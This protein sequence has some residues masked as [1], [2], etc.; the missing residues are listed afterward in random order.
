MRQEADIVTG[1]APTGLL[2]QLARDSSGNTL[3]MIAAAVLPL[4]AMVGGGIDMGRSYLS[5]TRLQQA[6]DAGVLAARKKLGSA[7]VT[8]GQ[9][10][11]DVATVGNQFFNVNFQDGS[12]GTENRDFAMTLEQ[13]YAISGVATVNVP[14][15]IMTIFGYTDVPITVNCEARLNFSNTDIMFV[16]DTTG[17]M[18]D[19]N[20]G[21]SAP[22]I[23]GLREVVKSFHAQVEGSKGAGTRV[24]Y[25]FV[26][27]ATNVNVGGLL[28][29]DWMV[30]EWTYQSRIA[31]QIGTNPGYSGMAWFTVSATIL[32][33]S[34]SP[35]APY[36]SPTCPASTY[37]STVLS[38]TPIDPGPPQNYDVEYNENGNYYSCATS[39]GNY[40]VSGTAYNNVVTRYHIEERPYTYGPSPIWGY[41]Y[42]R[43]QFDVT[44]AKDA[45]SNAPSVIGATINAFT[46]SDTSANTYWYEGCIEERSTYEITDY[47]N[48]DLTRAL[49]LDLDLIPDV[50]DPDTQ[51]RPIYRGIAY[52]RSIW[53]DGSGTW[54]LAPVTDTQDDYIVPDWTYPTASCPG[55]ARK[56]EEMNNSDVAS[57]VDNLVVDG[58]TY[59]DIGMIWG[60][61]LLS[62]T[63]LFADENGD[64]DGK[65]T[66]RHMIFLTDGE[67]A[68]LDI[69][70][71]SYGVEPL[72]Q[73]R[74]SE[75]SALTLAETVEERFAAACKEVKKRNITVWVIGFGTTLNPIMTDCAGPGKSFEA[76]D[77]SELNE[78][79]SRIA[80]SIGDL[81]ISK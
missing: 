40:T 61:R 49:D 41:D 78:I 12:Y 10:P 52:D 5:Q 2:R 56:L 31:K 6:C 32:S 25:G 29:S 66:A 28:K 11:A 51:W 60:G 22:R 37:V 14:T 63:G 9:V 45:D 47:D 42:N 30:D 7:V 33:G 24:R 36:N 73:R 57:Y 23:D 1:N 8:D 26:P 79:F 76:S 27:Y 44:G 65:P 4:L 64:V 74:W 43:Y 39:D 68:P 18:G 3:A 53:W 20:P 16:L 67:T 77:T 19:T 13:S 81:R 72:D 58:A 34:T 71:S 21:D 38:Q 48:V 46:Y 80:A 17:S 75:G 55:A 69:L 15:T 50:N 54:S 62:P 70:H 59:H 35:I